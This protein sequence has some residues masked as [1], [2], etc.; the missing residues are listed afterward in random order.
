MVHLA[1]DGYVLVY[2]AI[3]H[4]VFSPGGDPPLRRSRQN[5]RLL[6]GGAVSRRITPKG[7]EQVT[8]EFFPNDSIAHSTH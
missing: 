6:Q 4:Y 2:A 8:G 3:E 1:E 7:L 5:D